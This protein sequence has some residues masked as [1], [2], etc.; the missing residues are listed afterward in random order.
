M[1]ERRLRLKLKLKVTF[2]LTFF[3]PSKIEPSTIFTLGLAI[4]ALCLD[5][6][7]STHKLFSSYCT[8]VQKNLAPPWPWCDVTTCWNLIG[9]Y[10]LHE[11]LR[12]ITNLGQ[13]D[14]RMDIRKSTAS[15]NN[16]WHWLCWVQ[17]G[18]T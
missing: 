6:L 13:P 4:H 2:F 17:S 7:C 5:P 1:L 11:P 9:Q 10:N 8:L 15:F 16:R 12:P 3:Y 18:F 14:I